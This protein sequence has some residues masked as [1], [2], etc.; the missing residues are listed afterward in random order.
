MVALG[1]G[2]IE[3][4]RKNRQAVSTSPVLITVGEV[5][6]D[7]AKPRRAEDRVGDGVR[8]DVGVGVSN[9]CS[10]A[11]EDHAAENQL[12]RRRIVGEGMDV[13]AEATRDVI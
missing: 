10:L 1:C 12:P 8:Y 5:H 2:Q 13:E 7:V 6:P 4:G 3:A 9:Q 11:G